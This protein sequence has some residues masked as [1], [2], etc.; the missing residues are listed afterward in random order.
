MKE[1]LSDIEHVIY[2][3]FE[4][5]LEK[6]DLP[7]D[8]EDKLWEAVE[9]LVS[10]CEDLA[11]ETTD[12]IDGEIENLERDYLPSYEEQIQSYNDFRQQEIYDIDRTY[13]FTR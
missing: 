13:N 7:E 2:K 3:H 10:D 9:L 6:A 12:Y 1:L 4:K 8:L 11:K 5:K